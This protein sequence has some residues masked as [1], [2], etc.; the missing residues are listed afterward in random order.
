MDW[1]GTLEG[2]FI[3]PEKGAPMQSVG[4]A[5]AVAGE[6]L[7]GDRYA[8]NRGSLSRWSPDKRQ[9]TLISAEALAELEA[10]SG[11]QLSGILSR[12][13]LLVSGAPLNELLGR[14]FLVGPVLMEGVRLCQPCK[15]LER[16]TGLDLLPAMIGKGGLRAKILT[17]GALLVGDPV[18]PSQRG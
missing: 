9:V 12:R 1:S 7:V 3:A 15:Y 4:F 10:E 5:R 8:E 6:G 14:R 11:V 13:N 17:D 18:S 2:I 16:K